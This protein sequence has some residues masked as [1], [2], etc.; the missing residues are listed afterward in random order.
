MKNL[1]SP[2]MGAFP[3]E[4]LVRE[5]FLASK[6]QRIG[7]VGVSK[8]QLWRLVKSGKFPRPTK[9]S[10]GVTVWRWGDVRLWLQA[11]FEGQQEVAY[12]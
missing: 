10:V 8:A 4:A 12:A 2:Q 9:L 6:G 5:S 1:I 11:R 7:V 3:D